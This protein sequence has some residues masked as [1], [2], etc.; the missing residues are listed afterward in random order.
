MISKTLLREV[1]LAHEKSLRTLIE[2][3]SFF[4][5][6][7]C[8]LN[9]FETYQSSEGIPLKFNDFVVTSM[10]R[11][12]K[13]IHYQNN[14][15]FE[16]LPGETFIIPPNSGFSVDFPEASENRPTQCVAL[17]IDKSVIV[18][19]L[20]LL[21]EKFPKEGKEQLWNIDF[22]A[23]YFYNSQDLACAIDKITKE[24]MSGSV[25]K[26]PL[27]Y[28]SLQEL[29]IR[30]IQSQTVGKLDSQQYAIT[31]LNNPVIFAVD[32]IKAN[33]GQQINI[34]ELS[35]SVCMSA[36]ALYRNFK[37]ELGMSPVEFMLKEK[38][39]YAKR[40]LNDPYIKINEVSFASGFENCNYFIRLFRKYEG[41]TPK[42]YQQ[43]SLLPI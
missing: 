20:D 6:K 26:D 39:K 27:T 12:K 28:L 42:Q 8:E 1:D 35:K 15:P 5:L 43:R 36:S 33:I 14:A 24:C 32:Y 13:R 17:A 25:V 41:I 38:I 2:N 34:K 4:T 3:R 31:D 10:I 29:I 23:F 40:L 7:H 30:I 16:Y 9:I 19:T 37:R 21:N 22:E 11:G 18:E